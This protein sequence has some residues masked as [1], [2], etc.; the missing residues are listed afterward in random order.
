MSEM[1]GE[2]LPELEPVTSLEAFFHESMDSAMAANKVM[3]DEHTAHYVVN[4]LTLFSRSEALYE[5]TPEG[6]AIRPLAGM[7][8]DAVDAQTEAER[9]TTLQ[10]MGDVSL[11]M[12][13]FFADGL[14]RAAVDVDYYVYMGG[15]AYHSLSVH[16]RSTFRGRALCDVFV[17]LSEKFQ[18]MVDILNEMRESARTMTDEN[19]LR[20]YELWT[21]TGSRRAERMLKQS[22]VYSLALARSEH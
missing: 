11:F 5:L 6:P 8:A 10:R 22:G 16:L 7:L 1:T 14:Q 18:D 17:E 4:L 2:S 12:A 9:N 15:G 19:L 20:T 21:K 13:G 3:L